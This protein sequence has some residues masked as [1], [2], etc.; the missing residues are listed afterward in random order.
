MGSRN[1]DRV[2]DVRGV[3]AAGMPGYR[4]DSVVFLGEGEDNSVHEVNGELIVR[5]SKEPDPRSRA[6]KVSGEARLLAAVAGVSPVPVPEPAFTVAEQGCL[7]YF[8]LPGLALIDV[9][10]PHRSAQ[11]TSVAAVL[12]ELLGGLHGV[13]VDSVAELVTP[14][15]QP[16]ALWLDEA[17]E[18]YAAVAERVPEAHRAALRA[19]LDAPPPADGHPLVFS[20]NDLGIEHVLI[21]PDTWEVTGVIDWSDAAIV[22]P[23]YDFGLILRDLGPDALHRALRGYPAGAHEVE[24]IGERAAFYARCAVLEDM[25]YGIETGRHIYLDKSLAALRWLCPTR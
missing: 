6:A 2:E 4:V 13:P 25:A 12:G 1:R 22:D 10:L 16:K 20:H 18:T 23:A 8:K 7:G 15:D 5:F 11:G 14:D 17:R 24:A 19:F 3:V 9:P 21:D